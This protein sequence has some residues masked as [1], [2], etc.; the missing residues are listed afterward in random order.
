M[1]SL[2]PYLLG[3]NDTPE[4]GIYT[5]DAK[6]LV[7]EISP[8]TIDACIT[9][10]PFFMPAYHYQSRIDWGRSWS[11]TLVLSHW[12]EMICDE[13]KRV[14]KHTGHVLSFSGGESYAAFFPVMFERWEYVRPIVWDKMR[15]G[16]GRI[17]RHQHEFI[18]CARNKASYVPQDGKL[19]SDVL[20]HEAKLSRDRIHPVE[21]PI[22]LLVD[23][24]YATTPP[25][26]IVFDP[27]AGSCSLAIA[28]KLTGRKFLCFEAND[29]YAELARQHIKG[30]QPLLPLE[31]PTQEVLL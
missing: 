6:D 28:A 7:S 3:P 9:D 24:I 15:V 12:W 19:R 13:L 5:G 23:L 21:K 26:A 30:V 27:F 29:K 2:G 11:D 25:G 17:W 10:P 20:R 1:D 4:N 18:L 8:D 22:S 16:L 14:V 31:M